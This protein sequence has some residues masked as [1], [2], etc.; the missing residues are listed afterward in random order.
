[1]VDSGAGGCAPELKLRAEF[2]DRFKRGRQ[3]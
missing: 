2:F 1:M 3:F